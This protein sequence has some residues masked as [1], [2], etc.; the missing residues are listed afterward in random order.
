MD[1]NAA[2]DAMIQ[3]ERDGDWDAVAE[4]ADNLRA[5][6]NRDGFEPDRPNWRAFTANAVARSRNAHRGQTV[7]EANGMGMS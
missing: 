7:A 4:H 1:P 3:A 2:Y 5:W 6:I